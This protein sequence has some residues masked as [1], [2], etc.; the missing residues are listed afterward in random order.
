MQLAMNLSECRGYIVVVVCDRQRMGTRGDDLDELLEQHLAVTRDSAAR[1]TG[2]SLRQLDYWANTA[3]IRPSADTK[4]TPGRRIRL[5]GFTDLLALMVAAEL[6]A[7]KIS[8]QHI[9]TIVAHL[10]RRGYA[11]PL[12]EL[13]FATQGDHVYFQHEDGA[14]EGDAHPDQVVMHEVLNLRLLRT[15]IT[16]RSRRDSA[17]AGQV[18]R[19][20]GA[21][22]SKPV[23]AG[24]RVPVHTVR[25]YLDQ[26]RTVAEILESFPDL[27]VEDVEAVRTGVA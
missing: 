15:R 13:A 4:L 24:T 2:L 12:T 21:M 26:G 20:R 25:R 7:R 6:K 1:I 3:L 16:E 8:L 14:W 27:T 18:E 23:F 19:R 5:Y 22:G 10:R 9:R 17:L 11:N